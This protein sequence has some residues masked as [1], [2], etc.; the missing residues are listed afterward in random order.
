MRITVHIDTFDRTCP[1]GYV[2]LD[3]DRDAR[4]WIFSSQCGLV[5]P[6]EG[7]LVPASNG[8]LVCSPTD[9]GHLCLLEGLDTVSSDG[10]LEGK[11]GPTMWYAD[12]GIQPV[13]GH[14]HVEF[15]E[16][17]ENSP[18]RSRTSDESP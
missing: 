11:T 10:P 9:Q 3:I 4:Q 17:C 18:G 16:G 15:A 14:W 8:T 1:C 7:P 2:I 13:A 5:I 6:A 12:L